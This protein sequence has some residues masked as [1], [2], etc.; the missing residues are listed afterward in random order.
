MSTHP[1]DEARRRRIQSTPWPLGQGDVY[2]EI[3]AHASN[4]S[5]WQKD[6][7]AARDLTTTWQDSG[8]AR[9][10]VTRAAENL[11]RTYFAPLWRAKKAARNIRYRVD[12]ALHVGARLQRDYDHAQRDLQSLVREVEELKAQLQ[13]PRALERP[14]R[15]ARTQKKIALQERAI[16]RKSKAV[17]KLKARLSKHEAKIK[18]LE[19]HEQ[20]LVNAGARPR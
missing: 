4:Y 5:A 11:I 8:G 3:P 19:E 9:G 15:V 7:A 18:N 16:T 2:P 13:D 10:P 12:A 17:D 6:L 20:K 14:T 1:A